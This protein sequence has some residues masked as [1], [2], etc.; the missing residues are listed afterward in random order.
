MSINNG[1]VSD[2]NKFEP[3][4][5]I[6]SH[7]DRISPHQSKQE[8]SQSRALNQLKIMAKVSSINNKFSIIWFFLINVGTELVGNRIK[9]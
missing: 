5:S 1:K 8:D 9:I 2:R 4:H 6:S 3:H 7:L